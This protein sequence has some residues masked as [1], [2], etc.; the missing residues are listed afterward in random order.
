M[1]GEP[2]YRRR[3]RGL[4][5][6]LARLPITLYRLRLGWLFGRRFLLLHHVGRK[7]G[8]PRRVVLEVVEHDPLSGSYVVAAAW[9]PRADWLRN[10]EA[11]PQA[12]IEVG[13]RRVEVVAQRLDQEQAERVF[14]EY[15]RRYPFALRILSRVMGYQVRGTQED[16]RQL[17][18]LVPLVRLRPRAAA[19]EG[20]EQEGTA[21]NS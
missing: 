3:P 5:R 9:G 14:R 11:H 8:L 19:P 10:L 1:G 12:S 17:A 2:L 20:G 21:V 15:A 16:I 13:L 7:T 18:A 4:L 6:W